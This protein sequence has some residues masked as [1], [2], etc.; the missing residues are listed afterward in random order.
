MSIV[1]AG[2]GIGGTLISPLAT[3]LIINFGWRMPRLYITGIF[4][5]ASLIPIIFI[6]KPEPEDMGLKPYGL[7]DGEDNSEILAKSPN[8]DVGINIPM[9]ETRKKSI[10]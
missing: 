4:L 6:L 10:Y 1:L 2:I 8:N 7:E 9:S 3:Y 5:I